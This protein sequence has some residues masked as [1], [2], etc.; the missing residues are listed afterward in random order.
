M[1]YTYQRTVTS[2][3][4]QRRETSIV[5]PLGVAIATP[6][7]VHNQLDGR[8]ATGA[9]PAAAITESTAKNFVSL[10]QKGLV[11]TALQPGDVGSAAAED[12]EAFATAAQ[13]GLA[14]S[15][16][17][18]G[19]LG[20]PDVAGFAEGDPAKLAN[21]AANA[22][23]YS[24]PNHTGDVASVGDGAQTIA[25]RAVTA[26]KL[27]ALATARFL[28]RISAESG[29]VEQLTAAQLAAALTHNDIGTRTA[30][31]SHPETAISSAYTEL[32]V[33]AGA[34]TLTA[35]TGVSYLRASL[36]CDG[37]PV[38]FDVAGFTVSTVVDVVITDGGLISY[39]VGWLWQTDD[40]DAPTPPTA[41]IIHIHLEGKPDAAGTG[42]QI[43][44]WSLG[45][46]DDT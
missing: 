4:L 24:H 28:G 31:D 23:N 44:A 26:A 6:T 27:F 15:A 34:A 30:A 14:D 8:D 19:D 35:P 45:E 25:A 1:S 7:T 29:D 3:N 21:I 17:Q 43:W 22:N 46:R 41:G 33:A 37:G 2:Y 11:D 9:H 40:G 5:A 10:A 39:P 18:P 12:V 16:V 38:D 13:G 32:A 36:D 42:V 20:T